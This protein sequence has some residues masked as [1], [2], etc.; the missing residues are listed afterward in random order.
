LDR[1]TTYGTFKVGSWLSS[2]DTGNREQ[3]LKSCQ[4]WTNEHT[5][6]LLLELEALLQ[7]ES[8]IGSELVRTD[9]SKL[10]YATIV[11]NKYKGIPCA[12]LATGLTLVS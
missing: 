4:E 5:D 2:I 10:L 7:G 8:I 11:L 9:Q 6:L 1:N 12:A 3:L